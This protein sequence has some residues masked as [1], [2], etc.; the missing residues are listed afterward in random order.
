MMWD[1]SFAGMTL[2]SPSLLSSWH[3]FFFPH[4]HP[5]HC[6]F[7]FLVVCGL[8]FGLCFLV[9]TTTWRQDRTHFSAGRQ[10]KDPGQEDGCVG[11][12]GQCPAWLPKHSVCKTSILVPVRRCQDLSPPLACMFPPALVFSVC[13]VQTCLPSFHHSASMLFPSPSTNGSIGGI[14]ACKHF[15]CCVTRCHGP[16]AITYLP[17]CLP[18]LP[19]PLPTCFLSPSLPLY[20]LPL[21]L[22]QLITLPCLPFHTLLH[23]LFLL[24]ILVWFCTHFTTTT[25]SC[26][27]RFASPLPFLLLLHFALRWGVFHYYTCTCLPSTT[28]LLYAYFVRTYHPTKLPCHSCLLLTP[29]PAFACF[30]LLYTHLWLYTWLCLPVCTCLPF[31][32]YCLPCTCTRKTNMPFSYPFTTPAHHFSPACLTTTSSSLVG[33]FWFDRTEQFRTLSSAV[34]SER[35][36]FSAAAWHLLRAHTRSLLRQ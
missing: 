21:P 4:P 35:A 3:C 20:L 33:W 17:V 18:T 14:N 7:F 36:F 10:E 22:S 15:R 11:L 30:C 8:D 34:L 31:P 16:A 12:L 26:H 19:L 25:P 32:L 5:W 13:V 2:F 9:G 27:T 1:G 6:F 24:C 29:L 28:T 23:A